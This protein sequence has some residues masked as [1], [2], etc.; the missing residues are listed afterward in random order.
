[1]QNNSQIDDFIKDYNLQ[2]YLNEIKKYVKKHFDDFNIEYE[3]DDDILFVCVYSDLD[4]NI[5]FNKMVTI[6]KECKVLKNEIAVK[7]IN[8][9]AM[10]R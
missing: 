3:L 1:M 6:R 5:S 7:H 4:Y 2:Y 8:L 9:T 10:K